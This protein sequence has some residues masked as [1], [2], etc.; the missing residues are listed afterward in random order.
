MTCKLSPAYI[1][2][3]EYKV[4]CTKVVNRRLLSYFYVTSKNYLPREMLFVKSEN[5]LFP[6]GDNFTIE[7]KI[8]ESC[9]YINIT[10]F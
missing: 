4:E 10:I 3:S 8:G 1:I 5:T 9:F 7:I 6:K 2:T